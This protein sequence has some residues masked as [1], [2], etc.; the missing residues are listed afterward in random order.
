M[1]LA[2]C[3]A[4][5]LHLIDDQENRVIAL[6]GKWGTGKTELWKQVRGQ[7]VDAKAKDAVLVSLFGVS[8]ITE[9]KLKIAE[10][11][12]PRLG[13]GHFEAIKAGIAGFKKV[14]KGFHSSFSALDELSLLAVPYMLKGRFIVIDDIERKHTK[15][16][17]DEILGFIDECV[18]NH[19]CRILLVLNS[20]KLED[21][22]LWGQIRE[23]VV[24]QEIKLETSPS[25]AFDIAHQLTS[26]PWPQP[27][28]VALEPLQIT[29]IRIIRKIIRVANQLLG[30]DPALTPLVLKRVLPSICLLSAIHYEAVEDAPSMEFILGYQGHRTAT[31]INLWGKHSTPLS[32]EQQKHERWH[33]MMTRVGIPSTDEL[34]GMIIAF[35]LS[36]IMD[37]ARIQDFVSKHLQRSERI[38]ARNKATTFE[39]HLAWHP[40]L[41]DKDLILE[42]EALLPCAGLLDMKRL[43]SLIPSIDQLTGEQQLGM[44]FIE[45]WRAQF[46]AQYPD[47][48]TDD[49]L[50]FNDHSLDQ[51]HPLIQDEI[52]SAR[53]A[54]L[55]RHT[56]LGLIQEL[57]KGN[58][59]GVS[60]IQFLRSITAQEFKKEIKAATGSELQ[61]LLQKG[62]ELATNRSVP[63]GD[64]GN[65]PQAFLQA[66]QSIFDHEPQSRLASILQR[67]AKLAGADAQFESKDLALTQAQE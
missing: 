34:E 47:G 21:Q 52:D 10:G 16:T 50:H 49:W 30:Q 1:T 5:L 23:K 38:E 65:A 40:E 36:G 4:A 7:T 8:T 51:L 48:V 12:A 6:S 57:M 42:L 9:L 53:A 61:L 37:S 54:S 63:E 46:Q 28:K 3:K 56:V 2:R 41:S 15:L 55:N 31:L 25:E 35:L 39:K 58:D 19:E 33:R 18:Q 22:K 27:L 43:S 17:I 45:K 60:E 11:L 44:A 14:L 29:N 64:Y 67:E 62:F 26:C 24:D 13:E 20:D 66:C 32:E 59:W